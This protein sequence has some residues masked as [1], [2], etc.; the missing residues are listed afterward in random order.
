PQS[1]Q[2]LKNQKKKTVKRTLALP[3][4]SV[5]VI[6]IDAKKARKRKSRGKKALLGKRNTQKRK[7]AETES[8]TES[9]TEVSSVNDDEVISDSSIS[10]SNEDLEDLT[11]LSEN[12]VAA[13]PMLNDTSFSEMMSEVIE[14]LH[15]HLEANRLSF[16]D[17]VNIT[18]NSEI[19]ADI[20]APCTDEKTTSSKKRVTPLACQVIEVDT[21]STKIVQV[22][23][24]DHVAIKHGQIIFPAMINRI[25]DHDDS[26]YWIQFF[27]EIS[28]NKWSLEQKQFSAIHTDFF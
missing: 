6:R 25:D 22:N 17:L 15:L 21:D 16:I 4:E 20:H 19:E 26:V 14:S 28:K 5:P 12:N 2:T 13:L 9:D 11:C 10:D 23:V 27:K 3:D 8:D 7:R 18:M 24:G 1:L